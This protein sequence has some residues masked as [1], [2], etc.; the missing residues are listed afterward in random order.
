MVGD[1]R[2]I[3]LRESY[4]NNFDRNKSQSAEYPSLLSSSSNYQPA[5]TQW[6]ESAD[7]VRLEN[8][9]LSYNLSKEITKFADLR[10]T[11][12]CQNLITLT[13]YKGFDPASSS[14][15]SS[16]VDINSGI[17]MG[18]YPSPRT[19]TFGVKMNF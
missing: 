7:Y 17:D 13:G 19:V 18:A 14:F 5:S 10:L 15:S 12:S 1:S 6:L 11:L 3:T 8:I 4:M 2:F 16:N 9:S